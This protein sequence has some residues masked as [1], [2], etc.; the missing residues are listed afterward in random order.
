MSEAPRRHATRGPRL[1]ILDYVPH[2]EIMH[3]ADSS[4]RITSRHRRISVTI[5]E[6]GRHVSAP[7]TAADWALPFSRIARRA[8][9]TDKCNVVPVGRDGDFVL[10]RGGVVYRYDAAARALER[11]LVLERCRV[12]LHCGIAQPR[13]GRLY[14][15]EY[16]RNLGMREV[17]VHASRDGGR[18]WERAY[19]LPAGLARHGHGCYWD[20]FERKIWITT[21]DFPG[22][23]YVFV[24]DEEFRNVERIGDGSQVYRSVAPLFEADAVHW[25]MD[26]PL[27]QSCHVR[28]DRATRCVERGQRFAAPVWYTKSLSDGWRLAATSVEPGPAVSTNRATVY[29]TRDYSHWHE[30][31]AFEHDGLSM[32]L[33]KFGVIAFAD[34]LQSS[35]EF[36]IFGE[37]LRGLDGSVARCR[38]VESVD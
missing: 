33:F 15:V 22:Q 29:A 34:G 18:T 21:G 10:V 19:A 31:A 30:V 6:I 17:P 1:E 8:L 14:L 20:P 3:Y 26:S 16:G 24:A 23:C 4:T 27:E 37:A 7:R 11:V 13:Q 32:K 38:L 12:V 2:T 28:L 35:E 25:I 36:Y 9:R 5:G